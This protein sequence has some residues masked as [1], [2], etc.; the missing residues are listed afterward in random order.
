MSGEAYEER[1]RQRI[2]HKYEQEL[3]EIS[4]MWRETRHPIRSVRTLHQHFFLQGA[5]IKK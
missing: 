3:E 5:H 4:R 1:H 2:Q